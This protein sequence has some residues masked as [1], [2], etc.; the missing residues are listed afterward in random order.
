VEDRHFQDL[1][2]TGRRVQTK[3]GGTEIIVDE[4]RGRASLGRGVLLCQTARCKTF[5]PKTLTLEDIRK[6]RKALPKNGYG[7]RGC[8]RNGGL[9]FYQGTRMSNIASSNNLE[10]KESVRRNLYYREHYQDEYLTQ[11]APLSA[12]L[13]NSVCKTHR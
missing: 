3:P 8:T 2:E 1:V 6:T 9:N 10:S 4:E 13:T 5:H 12:V 11:I 7:S